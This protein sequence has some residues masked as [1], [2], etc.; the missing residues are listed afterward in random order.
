MK[1]I[2]FSKKLFYSMT[3]KYIN[4]FLFINLDQIK[5]SLTIRLQAIQPPKLG[6]WNCRWLSFIFTFCIWVIPSKYGR[7]SKTRSFLYNFEG[8]LFSATEKRIRVS[9]VSF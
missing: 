3:L 9:C 4:Y 8:Y 2:I 6:K 5:L 7:Y 1:N